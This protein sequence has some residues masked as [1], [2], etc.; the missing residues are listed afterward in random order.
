MP[1]GWAQDITSPQLIAQADFWYPT[2]TAN[3]S[4]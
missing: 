2:G 3:T 1:Y 4:G